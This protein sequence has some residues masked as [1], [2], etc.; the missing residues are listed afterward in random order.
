MNQATTDGSQHPPTNTRIHQPARRLLLEWLLITVGL[1]AIALAA[2]THALRPDNNWSSLHRVDALVHDSLG[3]LVTLP[4]SSALLL[5]VIDDASLAQLGRWPWRRAVHAAMIDQLVAAGATTIA[6]DMM[7]VEAHSDDALLAQAMQAA[8]AAGVRILLAISKTDAGAGLVDPLYPVPELGLLS[9]LGHAHFRIDGD[10][11]V[12]GQHLNEAGFASLALLM[13]PPTQRTALQPIAQHALAESAASFSNHSTERAVALAQWPTHDFVRLAPMQANL[14]PRSY[15]QVLAAAPGTLN[16]RNRV[17]LIGATAAGVGDQYANTLTG[18]NSIAPG[19]ELHAAAF[20]AIAQRKLMLVLP[21]ALAGGLCAAAVLIVMVALYG[22]RPRAGL[23]FTLAALATILALC[24]AIRFFGWWWPPSAALLLVAIAYPLWSWR[25]LEVATAGLL[26]QAQSLALEPSV[27]RPPAPT[28]Y[29][30]AE[31]IAR[32]VQQLQQAANDSIAWRRLMETTLHKLPHPALLADQAG[33]LVLRNEAFARSFDGSLNL[34]N[35]LDPWLKQT[36]DLSI[37]ALA[38]V[39]Q[40]RSDAQG[41]DWLIEWARLQGSMDDSWQL[42]QFVDL[43]EIRAAQR[44]R[45]QTLR[46]LSHDLRN[47]LLSILTLLGQP[48]NSAPGTSAQIEQ[49]AQRS[50]E[51]AE[52]FVQ[53]SRAEVQQ[54]TPEPL[55]LAQLL[56]EASDQCFAQARQRGVKLLCPAH[57]EAAILGDAQLLRRALINLIDNAIKFSP[58]GSKIE[59]AIERVGTDWCAAVNDRGPGLSDHELSHLFEPFWR[60]GS[61]Q[62]SAGAGLGLSFV[63]V[64]AQRHH[65]AIR[66]LVRDGGGTR[67]ELQLPAAELR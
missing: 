55:D 46:F 31:P 57:A 10:G 11:V 43:T 15:A 34:G 65:G 26:R 4:V 18:S 17:V 19:V 47:P 2:T 61:Q 41:R 22:L 5:I 62:H 39:S 28:G 29:L 9:E 50:L 64:V 8:R 3:T 21:S 54:I 27:S 37:D 58:T 13:V 24:A 66:A 53:L 48:A 60:S 23:L 51:L 32:S 20:S 25:R 63:K 33:K 67:F 12:R 45:E 14:E 56:I 16:L 44:E 1:M 49:L 30:P 6:L 42:M 52:G 38:R 35:T 7:F 40:E 59:L 36:F